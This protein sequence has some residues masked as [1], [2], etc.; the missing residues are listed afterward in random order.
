M[1]DGS[2]GRRAPS[3]APRSNRTDLRVRDATP[4]DMAAIQAIYA[5]HVL[6]GLASFEEEPPPLAEMCSRREAVLAAGLP[7]LAAELAGEVVGY[8]YAIAYRARAAY[9][10]TLEDSVYVAPGRQGQG[11]G[12]ALLADLIDRCAAGV[13]RQ[14]LAVIGDSANTGSIA[15]HRSLGFEMSGTLKSVGFKFGRWVDTVHMQRLL[16]DGDRSLP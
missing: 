13:W 7:Y 10:Y 14:M 2:I 11:I 16:G 5:H 15:L 12:R 4:A 1:N 6:H 3:E 8:S 9:R